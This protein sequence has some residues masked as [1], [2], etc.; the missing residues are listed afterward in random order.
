MCT[1]R[2]RTPPPRDAYVR[3]RACYA[4][5][6]PAR[7]P[8][9]TAAGLARVG[10]PGV[11]GGSAG[12]GSSGCAARGGRGRQCGAGNARKRSAAPA[13]AAR[14]AAAG[15]RGGGGRVAA[16]HPAVPARFHTA[17]PPDPQRS[18]AY[19]RAGGGRR[20]QV[21]GWAKLRRGPQ[22]ES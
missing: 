19:A 8:A 15:K 6:T 7:L 9:W 12:G 10:T 13:P 22:S 11:A 14:H 1:V 4:R 3:S 17:R 20:G 2:R 5:R 16:L 18:R 21:T